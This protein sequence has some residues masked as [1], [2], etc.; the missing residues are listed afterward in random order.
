MPR[1]GRSRPSTPSPIAAAVRRDR[2][3]SVGVVAVV[4]ALLALTAWRLYR[5]ESGPRELDTVRVARVVDGDTLLLESG[6][7]VRLL[8]VDTPET[9]HPDRPP[10]PWGAEASAFAAAAVARAS[11]VRLEYDI[12]RTDRYGRTL[13]WVWVGPDLLN[14]ALVEN[15]LSP[16]VL[17]SPLRP[18]Y[19]RRLIEAERTARERQIGIWSETTTP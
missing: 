19:R 16:A 2:R 9:K 15:G 18:D 13:A 5:G 17:L 6:R 10:E 14:V 3:R 12:E 7:R 11:D 4:L 1:P 8:G